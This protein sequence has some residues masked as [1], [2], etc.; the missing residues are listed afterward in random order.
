MSTLNQLQ[1]ILD[2]L[3]SSIPD[4][5]GVVISSTDGMPIAQNV[6]T[7]SDINRMAAM[8]ATALGL[9]KR[10]SEAF[11]G[12]ALNETS[13]SGQQAQIYIYSAGSKAVLAVIS[14]TGGN[15]GLIHLEARDAAQKI[16]QI[17]L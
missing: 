3:K 13:V 15:V 7:G 2:N 12:G 10:I 6:A 8:V 16:A 11:G 1:V 17:L 14:G 9:G 4:A 5:R